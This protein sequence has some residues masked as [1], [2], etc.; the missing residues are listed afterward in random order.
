MS[1]WHI[2]QPGAPQFALRQLALERAREISLVMSGQFTASDYPFQCMVVGL[3]PHVDRHN[4]K[5]TFEPQVAD[6]LDRDVLSDPMRS[7]RRFRLASSPG[8]SRKLRNHL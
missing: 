3:E 4:L 1:D 6:L 7:H 5:M 2:A 8:A